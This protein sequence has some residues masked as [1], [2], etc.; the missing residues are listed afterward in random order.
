[1]ASERPSS[2][3]VLSVKPNA[4]TAMNEASTQ[5]GSARPVITVERQEFRNRNTTSTVSGAPSISASSTLRTAL[6]TRS[7]ASWTMSSLAPGG[8]VR[9]TGGRARP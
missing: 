3:I 6:P 8:S 4:H 9:L 1:M 2:D 7:P 5:T